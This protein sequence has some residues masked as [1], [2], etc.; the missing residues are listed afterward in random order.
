MRRLVALVAAVVALFSPIVPSAEA[1]TYDCP[2][3][4]GMPAHDDNGSGCLDPLWRTRAHGQYGQLSGPDV[5]LVGDSL[6]TLCKTFLTDR[7][8]AERLSWGV[9]YWSGRPT[10]AAVSWVL[11]LSVKPKVVFMEIGT[12]DIYNTTV[13]GHE[14]QRL[15]DGLARSGTEIMWMDV[16]AERPRHP[17][18]DMV[19]SRTINAQIWASPDITPV[20]WMAWFDANPNRRKAYIDAGGVHPIKPIGCEFMSAAV[21]P[22]VIAAAKAAKLKASKPR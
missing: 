22:P 15:V 12:N 3:V 2:A 9:S 21:T 14:I 10:Q 13:M 8:T 1:F 7:F 20:K 19:N 5:L 18:P 6:S 11:S 4:N 16:R 17:I